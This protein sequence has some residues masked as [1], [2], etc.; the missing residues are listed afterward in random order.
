MECNS[1]GIKMLAAILGGEPESEASRG[2]GDERM[3]IFR[4]PNGS[5]AVETNGDPIFEDQ[6]F[7]A[8]AEA[9]A[10]IEAGR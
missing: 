6:D 4:L 8:F 5:R 9:H 2:A 10:W 3:T 1:I 7:Q